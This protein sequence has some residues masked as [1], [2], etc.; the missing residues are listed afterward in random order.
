M[1]TMLRVNAFVCICVLCGVI[2]VAI[3]CVLFYFVTTEGD[4][5]VS[6]QRLKNNNNN[7]NK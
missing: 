4:V 6:F 1:L 7:N 2:F 5:H 3:G